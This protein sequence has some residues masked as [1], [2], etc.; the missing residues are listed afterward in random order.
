MKL[1]KA[2]KD[3]AEVLLKN[4]ETEA[5]LPYKNLSGGFA[6]AKITDIDDETISIEL[7]HGIQDGDEDTV[8]TERIQVFRKG[9]ELVPP[10]FMI[11]E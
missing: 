8:H 7:R 6:I 9:M 2:E 11:V 4:L 5:Y 10:A 3:G 1:S